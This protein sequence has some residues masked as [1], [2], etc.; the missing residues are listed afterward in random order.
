ME[1]EFENKGIHIQQ[2]KRVFV[3]DGNTEI[4]RPQFTNLGGKELRDGSWSFSND[5]KKA[6]YDIV[7]EDVSV[8]VKGISESPEQMTYDQ[9]KTVC[10]EN[11]LTVDSDDVDACVVAAD[12]TK[13]KLDENLVKEQIRGELEK[14]SDISKSDPKVVYDVIV[15]YFGDDIAPSYTDYIV[16][17]HEVLSDVS[18]VEIIQLSDIATFSDEEILDYCEVLGFDVDDDDVEK[19]ID[20]LFSKKTILGRELRDTIYHALVHELDETTGTP[21]EK[22][23]E[24]L[25]EVY[26]NEFSEKYEQRI[27]NITDEVVNYVHSETEDNDDEPE[28]LPVLEGFTFV[29]EEDPY[30]ESIIEKKTHQPKKRREKKTLEINAKTRRLFDEIREGTLHDIVSFTKHGVEF[31]S[32]ET[33]EGV[34]K[35][36]VKALME[37]QEGEDNKMYK[38]RRYITGKIALSNDLT[39]TP[40]TTLLLGYLITKKIQYSVRYDPH[41]E[42]AVS[43]VMVRV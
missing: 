8:D 15:A 17:Y 11:D 18:E 27:R 30:I 31:I 26:G 32:S 25:S 40:D 2:K 16:M 39:L 43:Y 19:C 1:A 14:M 42:A 34:T 9:I 10:K 33:L 22:I 6:V 5:V 36:D 29:A 37:R 13:P 3:L 12:E 4:Y 24:T 28:S 7:S 35:A 23:I 21:Q 38:L 20:N 41:V